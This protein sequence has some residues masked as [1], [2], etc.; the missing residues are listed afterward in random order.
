[1]IV[2]HYLK[3]NGEI[4]SWGSSSTPPKDNSNSHLAECVILT[5]E[6]DETTYD[7][8]AP[9][10]HKV[11][12]T[13]RT[14]VHKTKDE[15]AE[16]FMPSL[17]DIK[18]AI[19]EELTLTDIYINP[20]SDRPITGPFKFDWKPYRQIL[21]DLSKLKTPQAMIEAWPLRP[22]GD[23]IIPRLREAVVQSMMLKSLES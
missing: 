1:M 2:I 9:E 20:Q 15:I 22:N 12:L 3:S 19:L 18:S 10:T 8:I 7:E 14:L 17:F 4:K 13:N 6:Y 16:M 21:R 11:D 5:L 23:D